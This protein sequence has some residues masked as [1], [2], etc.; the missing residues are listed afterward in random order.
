MDLPRLVYFPEMCVSG[1]ML[2]LGRKNSPQKPLATPGPLIIYHC[3]QA[4]PSI[5]AEEKK[6]KREM[7]EGIKVP[8]T[9]QRECS[10]KI[11][12]I[13][14]PSG[15]LDFIERNGHVY[16]AFM[17]WITNK[18]SI[19]LWLILQDG[20]CL[21]IQK[22]ELNLLPR[23]ASLTSRYKNLSPLP[24][25]PLPAQHWWLLGMV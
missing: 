1:I 7:P 6:R 11:R 9:A 15:R 24:T 23:A 22:S 19:K 20:L 16:T 4:T 12:M 17:S 3:R 8:M 18:R 2:L 5:F 13:Y 14:A 25:P 10:G 21:I